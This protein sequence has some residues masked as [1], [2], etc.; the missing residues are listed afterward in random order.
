[1]ADE[2]LDNIELNVQNDLQ[3]DEFHA[4][5]VD[6]EQV[7]GDFIFESPEIKYH[8]QDWEGPFD[9]LYALI[10][11]AKI[12]IEDIFISDVTSQYVEIVTNQP[13]DEID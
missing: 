1:M 7:E 5:I 10:K 6:P 8:L 12:N 2:F 3:N 4:E 9:L 13:K 11:S